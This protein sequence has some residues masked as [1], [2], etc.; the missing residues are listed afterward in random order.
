MRYDGRAMRALILSGL[1][2]AGLVLLACGLPRGEQELK[3]DC[4]T[5]GPACPPCTTDDDCV[6]V[7]NTC[8]SSAVC[9]HR[10]RQ[11]TLSVTQIGCDSEYDRPPPA[12][13]GCVQSVCRTR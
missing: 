2:G 5:S 8:N 13:C 3:D 12:K 11:P 7:S 9:T 4:P 1:A 10:K 6:I